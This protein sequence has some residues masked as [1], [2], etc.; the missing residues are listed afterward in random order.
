VPMSGRYKE[1]LNSDAAA[2]GGENAGNLGGVDAEPV[3]WQGYPC[4]VVLML[5]PLAVVFLKRK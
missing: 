2:Y 1:L 3:P 4:S 5:P